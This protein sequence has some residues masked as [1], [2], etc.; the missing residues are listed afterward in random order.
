MMVIFILILMVLLNAD[1]MVMSPN[2]G[3]IEHE[4]GITDVQIGFVA[5]SSTALGAALKVSAY[6]W[7]ICAVLLLI[8]VFYFSKDVEK[9]QRAMM[10]LAR[11][12]S[13]S[14]SSQQL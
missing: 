5:S 2:I 6:F 1:Q 3:A 13:A 10:K 4:F 8:L 11:V 7:L 12:S 14:K 9:L